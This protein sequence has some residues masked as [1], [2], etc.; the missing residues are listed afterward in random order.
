MTTIMR[1]ANPD[2]VKQVVNQVLHLRHLVDDPEV[3]DLAM[4]ISRPT[5]DILLHVMEEWVEVCQSLSQNRLVAPMLIRMRGLCGTQ[6][7]IGF[8]VGF[9]KAGVVLIVVVQVQTEL[10]RQ[11]FQAS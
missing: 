9:R 3:S 2:I 6:D 1:G 11:C 8:A 5:R 10:I 4:M 7:L